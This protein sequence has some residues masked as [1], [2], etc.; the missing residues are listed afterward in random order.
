MRLMDMARDWLRAQRA[1]LHTH[2]GVWRGND[3]DTG[4]DRSLPG[5]SDMAAQKATE[6]RRAAE[7]R[8]RAARVA[9][10]AAALRRQME[11]QGFAVPREGAR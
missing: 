5:R 11:V 10:N 7:L 4:R 6:L 8:E 1:R 2:W 3:R 9:L